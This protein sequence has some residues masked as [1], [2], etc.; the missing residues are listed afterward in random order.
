VK[1]A[2][3]AL[4]KHLIDNYSV[5]IKRRDKIEVTRKSRWLIRHRNNKIVP[6]EALL[7][8]SHAQK[9]QHNIHHPL[10][11]IRPVSRRR[12]PAR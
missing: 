12:L 3:V 2:T 9:K 11:L 10:Y 1:R 6:K 7:K 5:I 8:V 4:E